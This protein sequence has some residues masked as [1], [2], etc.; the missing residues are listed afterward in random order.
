MPLKEI[1]HENT[2]I[3]K[4]VCNDLNLKDVYVG[5]TTDF[6]KRKYT[7]KYSCNHA[8]TKNYNLK[9]YQMIRANGGWDNWTM[10][11]IEKYPCYDP[12]EAHA[13]ERY[14]Y[15]QFNTTMNTFRPHL[16]EDEKQDYCKQYNKEYK[17]KNNDKLI[18]KTK[19]YYEKNKDKIKKYYEENKD[20]IKE[21][22]KQYKEKNITKIQAYNESNK[23]NKR[24]YDIKYKERNGDKYKDTIKCECGCVIT[25]NSKS[26]HQKSDKHTKYT[27]ETIMVEK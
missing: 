22:H 12:N 5:S 9:V 1:N 14:W 2:V 17:V 10:V 24:E 18:D 6:T 16:S 23:A 25:L 21:T 4:I 7:H 19:Q 20:K 8:L 11:E 26:R 15:E 13:R 27:N 3:Y